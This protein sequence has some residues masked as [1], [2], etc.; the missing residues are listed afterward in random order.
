M[1][2]F[3]ARAITPVQPCMSWVQHKCAWTGCTYFKL[4]GPDFSAA[5]AHV[6]T[7]RLCRLDVEVFHEPP[8]TI[9]AG[10]RAGFERVVNGI[11]HLTG[12]NVAEHLALGGTSPAKAIMSSRPQRSIDIHV[13]HVEGQADALVETVPVVRNGHYASSGQIK[14]CF[15]CCP[16]LY[17]GCSSFCPTWRSLLRFFY[18]RSCL[19][20]PFVSLGH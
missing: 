8:F 10:R 18:A 9:P 12:T 15:H 3:N 4:S 20:D 5:Q 13:F 17:E 11:I 14:Q 19:I 16:C 2:A 1:T 6:Q 7:Q